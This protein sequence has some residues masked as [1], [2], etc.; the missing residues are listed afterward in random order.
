MEKRAFFRRR[1]LLVLLL[2]AAAAAALWLL[3][4]AFAGRPLYAEIRQNGAVIKTIPLNT[5]RDEVFSL[6]EAPQVVF[7]LYSDGSICFEESDC[8]DLVCVRSGR[9][10]RSD[11][12]AICLP[13]RLALQIKGDKSDSDVTVG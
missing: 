7:H 5:G 1:D 12:S 6:S 4:P 8:P 9:I 2:L 10:S 11:Q 13:N 3:M